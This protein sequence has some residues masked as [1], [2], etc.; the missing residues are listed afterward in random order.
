MELDI[1]RINTILREGD[2][3]SEVSNIAKEAL[4]QSIKIKQQQKKISSTKTLSL[5][6]T[7]INKA[8]I[9]KR[10]NLKVYQNLPKGIRIVAG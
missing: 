9:E 5:D 6:F 3:H 10:G 4:E 2:F 7:E 1:K 8:A